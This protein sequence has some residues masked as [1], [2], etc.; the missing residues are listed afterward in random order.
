MQVFIIR[1]NCQSDYMVILLVGNS[2]TFD[3]IVISCDVAG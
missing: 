3:Q 1:M 2:L